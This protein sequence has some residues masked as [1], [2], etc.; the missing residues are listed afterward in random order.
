MCVC[1]VGV[2]GYAGVASCVV[3]GVDD[4]VV[5]ELRL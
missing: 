2:V 4:D 3:V 5:T 1:V